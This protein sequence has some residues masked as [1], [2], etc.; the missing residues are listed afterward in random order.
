[1]KSI[2]KN[3]LATAVAVRTEVKKKVPKKRNI[4]GNGTSKNHLNNAVQIKNTKSVFPTIKPD[5]SLYKY[6]NIDSEF[7]S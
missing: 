2:E 4:N 1:M 7:F 5:T 6:N 3:N